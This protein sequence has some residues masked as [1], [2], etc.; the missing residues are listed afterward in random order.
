M[1]II[2]ILYRLQLI[3]CIIHSHVVVSWFELFFACHRCRV[4]S[5]PIAVCRRTSRTQFFSRNYIYVGC[6]IV[7]VYLH[8]T[9]VNAVSTVPC[10]YHFPIIFNKTRGWWVFFFWI[11]RDVCAHSTRVPIL[12]CVNARRPGR[13][14]WWSR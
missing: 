5:L 7:I 12:Y 9:R 10:V 6:N 13:V 11:R 3:R 14:M 1:Y 4:Y 2:Y 8:Y